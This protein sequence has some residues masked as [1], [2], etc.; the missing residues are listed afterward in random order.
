MF[1]HSKLQ[2][3]YKA[4][5]TTSYHLLYLSCCPLIMLNNNGSMVLDQKKVACPLRARVESLP[6]VELQVSW[7]LAYSWNPTETIVLSTA[8]DKPV[9]G[10]F[11]GS[12]SKEADAAYTLFKKHCRRE[13]PDPSVQV[14]ESRLISSHQCWN[15]NLLAPVAGCSS[16][17]VGCMICLTWTHGQNPK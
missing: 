11:Q 16:V 2:V 13:R 14:R 9:I 3:R 17:L 7:S 5:N 8:K 10:H 15:P 4:N 1:T 12:N 6:Q